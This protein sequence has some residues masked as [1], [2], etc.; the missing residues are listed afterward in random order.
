[1]L[2]TVSG[3]MAAVDKMDGTG[4]HAGASGIVMPSW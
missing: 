3:T 4:T 2:I 1:M